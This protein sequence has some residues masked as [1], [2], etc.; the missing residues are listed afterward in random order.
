[1]RPSPFSSLRHAATASLPPSVSLLEAAADAPGADAGATRADAEPAPAPP[2]ASIAWCGR[3]KN[4]GCD[5]C[6][7]EARPV[8]DGKTREPKKKK[9]P[10]AGAAPPSESKRARP[11]TLL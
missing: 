3:C 2:T 11:S 6:G 4:R 8:P 7:G 10:P 5:R 1:M 9:G